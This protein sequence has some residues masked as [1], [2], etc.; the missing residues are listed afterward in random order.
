MR[1]IIAR[2]NVYERNLE[3][4][5]AKQSFATTR[6]VQGRA[7]RPRSRPTRPSRLQ[8]GDGSTSARPHMTSTA[9]RSAF[10][11]L[12][13]PAPIGGGDSNNPM[14]TRIYGTAF[15]NRKSS[16]SI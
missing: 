6:D 3:P 7:G 11:L 4:E 14:L 15:A 16:T 12:K 10:K 5:Q 2:D 9:S 1:E 13:S 8:Q